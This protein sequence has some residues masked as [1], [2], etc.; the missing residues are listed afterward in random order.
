MSVIVINADGLVT[1]NDLP[2]NFYSFAYEQVETNLIQPVRIN[3]RLIFWLDEEGSFRK[4]VNPYAT[5]LCAQFG[6]TA[7]A[8]YG[9]MMVTGGSIGTPGDIQD[10]DVSFILD[11]LEGTKRRVN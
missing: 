7:Q 6:L 10:V 2:E 8:L 5:Y 4:A 9:T 3:S 1:V 11:V